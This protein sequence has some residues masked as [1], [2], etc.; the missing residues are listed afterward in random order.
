MMDENDVGQYYIQWIDG[1][2]KLYQMV[3]YMPHPSITMQDVLSGGKISFSIGSLL[4][5]EFKK[6]QLPMLEGRPDP[7]NIFR[8]ACS[9]PFDYAQDEQSRTKE[10]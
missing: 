1:I 10:A 6:L 2:P 9:E 3:S 7:T 4:A 5:Q 8:I